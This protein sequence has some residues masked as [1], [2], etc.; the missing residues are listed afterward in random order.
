MATEILTT[1]DVPSEEMCYM[2]VLYPEHHL[3]PTY[4]ESLRYQYDE[5]VDQALDVL[6]AIAKEEAVSFPILLD[7]FLNETRRLDDPRLQFLLHQVKCAPDWVDWSFLRRG[8]IVFLAHAASASLSLLHRSLIG[9]FSAPKIL[10][11]LDCTGYLMT[12]E[13][14]TMTRIQ[15]T[16]E[17]ILNILDK[18]ALLPGQNGWRSV[19]KVRFLHSRVRKHILT[20]GFDVASYGI[21]INEADMIV[22]QLAFSYSVLFGIDKIGIS[23]IPTVHSIDNYPL[24]YVRVMANGSG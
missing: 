7:Q 13:Y 20:T 4:I 8:Q 3:H 18:D 10:K 19:L 2:P 22:T 9:G 14:S 5:V 11:V 1:S 17:M 21:P 15:D 12:N 23:F 6:Q 16:M 24:P